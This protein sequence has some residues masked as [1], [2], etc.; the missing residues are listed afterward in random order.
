VASQHKAVFGSACCVC[1]LLAAAAAVPAQTPATPPPAV[2]AP[3]ATPAPAPTFASEEAKKEA[4]AQVRL[5]A[6][7]VFELRDAAARVRGL[8]TIGRAACRYDKDFALETFLRAYPIVQRAAEREQF[9]LRRALIPQIAR[10][11][12]ALAYRLNAPK[13]EGGSAD[14]PATTSDVNSDLDAARVTLDED[15]AQAA[16]FAR[17]VADY[18][19][20]DQQLQSFIMALMALRQKNAEAAD[21]IFL[22]LLAKVRGELRPE[23]N[24]VLLLAN[25]LFSG[26]RFPGTRIEAA[27]VGVMFV[28]V[29]G[30]MTY[31]VGE[32]REGMNPQLVRPFL[33]AALDIF[34]RPVSDPRLQQFDYLALHQLLPHAQRYAPELAPLF[35]LRQ[36]ALNAS[37]PDRFRDPAT[38]R[39]LSPGGPTNSLSLE[40]RIAAEATPAGRDRWR[41]QPL[42]AAWTR[43]DIA[44]ARKFI[45]EIEDVDLRDRLN[46]LIAFFDTRKAIE[47]GRTEEAAEMIRKMPPGPKRALLALGL[48]SATRLSSADEALSWWKM[49]AKDA[50]AAD[51]RA[52]A[53]LLL[54]V[55]HRGFTLERATAMALL[56]RAVREFNAA[57][58][59]ADA[60]AQPRPEQSP[61][62]LTGPRTD[63]AADR[64]VVYAYPGGWYEEIQAGDFP[65]QFFLRVKDVT[66]WDFT[67]ALLGGVGA[68]APQAQAIVANLDEETR[69]SAALASLATAYLENAAAKAAPS[70]TKVQQP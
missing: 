29:G 70:P 4:L 50:E 6:D 9:V 67:P 39:L 25:Y 18:A 49:A 60:P 35:T 61:W 53:S 56:E 5:L 13:P 16:Q 26:P 59:P 63:P 51:P 69:R 47:A 17:R 46:A 45:A 14:Q 64:S 38:Y 41:V 66:V 8:A 20:T 40:Q 23:A 10:C 32:A 31:H 36:Q 37:V 52:R 54:A 7:Q 11:D 19:L 12:S 2:P 57:Y 21:S 58:K 65:S 44:E 24:R 43:D 28:S 33:E 48:S 15:P 30:L 62:A 27:S 55:T 1:L 34:S 42:Q 68:D 22:A 3:V